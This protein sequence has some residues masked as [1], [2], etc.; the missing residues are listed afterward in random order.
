MVGVGAVLGL[1]VPWAR[2]QLETVSKGLG[3]FEYI[4]KNIDAKLAEARAGV[5]GTLAEAEV[6]SA[7]A[8]AKVEQAASRVNAAKERVAQAELEVEESRSLNRIARLLEER[9]NSKSYEQYLGIVAAIRADFEKLSSLM[10]TMQ[11]EVSGGSAM[12]R[13]IDRIILYIDD[14]DRCPSDRVVRVLEAI[15][16]LLA[17]ELFV[18][19]VGLDI[20]WAARSLARST[21]S[22]VCWAF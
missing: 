8:A 3:Q 20:R 14:L 19:V 10:R 6:Q 18:V 7:A 9:L 11:D 15:H 5:Q 4:Q 21:P 17:F 12:L 2:R 13:P 16:L 22:S 1:A